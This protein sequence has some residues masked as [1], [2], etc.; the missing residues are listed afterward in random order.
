TV[1]VTAFS[2]SLPFGN[3]VLLVAVVT[4][5]CGLASVG[6]LSQLSTTAAI[7]PRSDRSISRRFRLQRGLV[8]CQIAVCFVLVVAA[9][10]FIGNVVRL[11]PADAGFAIDRVLSVDVRETVSAQPRDAAAIRRTI[12]TERG[13]DAVT[14]GSP[15]GPP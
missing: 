2:G 13:V 7:D 10:F 8:V 3:C 1:D 5:S 14:W 11:R 6:P 12:A 4:L 9:A 15:I